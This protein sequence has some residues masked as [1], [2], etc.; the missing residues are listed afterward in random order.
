MEVLMKQIFRL[1][2]VVFVV[3]SSI[4]CGSQPESNINEE[5]S[6]NISVPDTDSN[7][8]ETTTAEADP[9]NVDE[10]PGIPDKP[11]SEDGPWLIIDSWQGLFAVNPDGSGL[12]QFADGMVE[13]PFINQLIAAPSGGYF[14]Y[15]ENDGNLTDTAIRIISFPTRDLIVEIPLFSNSDNPDASA[16]RAILYEESMAFSPDGGQLAFMGVI[17]DPTSD[18]YRYSLES[19]DLLQLTNGPTQ[20]YQPVW[21]PDGKYILHTGADGFGTGAG[22]ETKGIWTAEAENADVKTLYTLTP[23]AA[24]MVLGWVDDETF[25]VYSWSQ[26]CG[27]NNLRTY[28][29]VSKQNTVIWVDPF[30]E[31]ALDPES[32]TIVLTS[33]EGNCGPEEGAGT[34]FIPVFGGKPERVAEYFGPTVE[35]VSAGKLFLVSSGYSDEWFFGVTTDGHIVDINRPTEANYFPALAPDTE[36]LFWPG[37]SPRISSIDTAIPTIEYFNEPIR[38]A[39]WT[40]D[41]QSIIF[42]AESGLYIAHQP[43]FSANQISPD[44]GMQSTAGYMAWLTP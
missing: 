18:L 37:D 22:F 2:L 14:A 23:N 36:Y 17:E 28:N 35:W 44:I 8:K 4:S 27:A 3:L 1:S 39:V 41:G 11:L 9:E 21:S 38:R 43:D 33:W 7:S 16:E 40:P 26:P 30:N 5:S 20:G 25:V 34:Y 10:A 12:T 24:E 13:S 29:I 32:G 15:Q 6:S 31:I 42:I 19:G